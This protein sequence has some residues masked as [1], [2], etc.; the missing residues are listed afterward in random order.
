MRRESYRLRVVRR[1]ARAAI[2]VSIFLFPAILHAQDSFVGHWEGTVTLPTKT[3][4]IQ[5]DFDHPAS[6][7]QGTILFPETTAPVYAA[8]S[9][10]VDA[11]RVRI[12]LEMGFSSV[13]LDGQLSGDRSKERSRRTAPRRNSRSNGRRERS[14]PAQN[15]RS[16][17]T[18][19]RSPAPMK[20]LRPDRRRLPAEAK[21][22]GRAGLK[23]RRWRRHRP[24]NRE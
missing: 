3:I 4:P 23:C 9:V 10:S 8:K 18:R 1:M 22:R 7:W 5:V 15:L 6:G 16:E 19:H 2:L 20:A 12:N 17:Q 11:G 21:G 14:L 13:S 24:A